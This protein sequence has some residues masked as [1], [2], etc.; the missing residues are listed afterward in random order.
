MIGNL[1]RTTTEFLVQL[2]YKAKSGE[3]RE[4]FEVWFGN[5]DFIIEG[6]N[7][8][9][10]VDRHQLEILVRNSYL[11]T[12]DTASN[13][14][15]FSITGKAYRDVEAY[16]SGTPTSVEQDIQPQTGNP[17]QVITI[18]GPVGALQTGPNSIANVTQNINANSAEIIGLLGQLRRNLAELP[19]EKQEDAADIL[20]VLQ[21]EVK[22]SEP[23]ARKISRSFKMLQRASRGIGRATQWGANLTILIT[24]LEEL[25]IPIEQLPDL[26][27]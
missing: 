23:D 15:T 21:E 1:N 14:K 4:Q 5:G 26:F 12:N 2:V 22:S 6:S 9:A 3:I 18:N 17:S 11:S 10:R 13:V 19:D 16:R 25:G 8:I 7:P 24:K 20:E 27:Q